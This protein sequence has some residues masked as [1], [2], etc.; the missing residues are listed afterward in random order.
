MQ[1]KNSFRYAA[2]VQWNSIPDNFRMTVD[3]NKFKS[4]ML[5]WNGENFKCAVSKAMS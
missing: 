4:F 1:Y 3:F 2:P 5:L